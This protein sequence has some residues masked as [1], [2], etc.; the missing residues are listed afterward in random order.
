MWDSSPEVKVIYLGTTFT[1]NIW[2]N[3]SSVVTGCN[4]TGNFWLSS[5]PQNLHSKSK[6]SRAQ[7]HVWWPVKHKGYITSTSGVVPLVAQIASQFH[8]M[9]LPGSKLLSRS[10]LIRLGQLE[11]K[12]G[13][14]LW[15]P[16]VQALWVKHLWSIWLNNRY[17]DFIIFKRNA[18]TKEWIDIIQNHKL[19]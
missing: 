10:L 14:K 4:D 17:W 16:M 18:W 6:M 9:A 19:S 7:L 8:Y 11:S 13:L 12:S 5:F 1:I 3:I 2:P 15:L